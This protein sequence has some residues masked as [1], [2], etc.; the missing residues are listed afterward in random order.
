MSYGIILIKILPAKFVKDFLNGNIYLNTDDFFTKV[1]SSDKVRF[2]LAEGADQSRQVKEIAIADKSGDYIPIEGLINPVI[3]RSANKDPINI[4]CMYAYN[5]KPD[6]FFDVSNLS[7]G[8]EA[9]IITDLKEFI[10]RLKNAAKSLSK[11][12]NHGPVTYVNKKTH[13]GVMGPFRKFDCYERQNEFRFVLSGGDGD[14]TYLQIGDIRD[15]TMMSTSSK[16]HL[17]PKG[18]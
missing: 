16:I 14:S 15:I 2:D 18:V 13:D 12:L 9:I 4:L 1:D 6:D 17:I 5:N 7:F 8:D 10:R 3:Y 11:T